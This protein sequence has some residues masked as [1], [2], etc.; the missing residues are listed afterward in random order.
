[1]RERNEH[2]VARA[3]VQA[4]GFCLTTICQNIFE[5]LERTT[6]PLDLDAQWKG[7]KILRMGRPPEWTSS[8]ALDPSRMK[9]ARTKSNSELDPG[10]P[11]QYNYRAENLP[12]KSPDPVPRQNMVSLICGDLVPRC[13]RKTRTRREEVVLRYLSHP[14]LGECRE[15]VMDFTHDFR[16]TAKRSMKPRNRWTKA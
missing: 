3:S 14:S 10:K 1:M 7:R 8:V 12:P 11:Y 9:F 4:G 16:S 5:Y 2:Q 15:A 13:S 6:P